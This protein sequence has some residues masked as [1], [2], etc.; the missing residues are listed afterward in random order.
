MQTF[1]VPL[2]IPHLT[3]IALSISVALGLMAFRASQVVPGRFRL[4]PL[5]CEHQSC[6]ELKNT[7]LQADTQS[8]CPCVDSGDPFLGKI[9]LSL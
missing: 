6:S 2:S 1:S 3:V 5:S 9:T 8:H 7:D 4:V